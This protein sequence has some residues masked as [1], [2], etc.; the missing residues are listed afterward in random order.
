MWPSRRARTTSPPCSSRT[1]RT[2]SSGS[3]TSDGDGRFDRRTV[4]ADRM[5]FPGERS[6]SRARSTSRAAEHLEAD[7]YRRRWRGRPP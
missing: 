6:G 2:G 1:N 5:M 4:F 7:R 3:R